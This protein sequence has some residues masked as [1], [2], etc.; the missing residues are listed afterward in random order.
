MTVLGIAL[1]AFLIA[2]FVPAL[3]WAFALAVVSEPL[4]SWIRAR[5]AS[6]TLSAGIAVFLV[7]VVLLVPTF[8]IVWQVGQ[9]AGQ[10][11]R[12]IVEFIDSGAL[13]KQ[14]DRLPGGGR[15]YD[16]V[17]YGG[18]PPSK[19]G[20]GQL[21][22]AVPEQAG[23]WLQAAAW[24]LTQSVVAL[25]VL[26]FLFR[27]RDAVLK[28]FRG[29]MPMSDAE[30]DYFF[31]RIRGMTHATIYGNV[32]TSIIQGALGGAMFTLLGIPS[33]LLWAVAMAFLS[34]IPFAGAFIIWLP[35]AVALAAH[36]EWGKAILLAAWGA[37]VVGTIDNIL[38]P[39]LV[40]KQAKL[41]T[42]A[43]FL[44][45]IGG[46]VAFGAPGLVLGPVVVAG[47]IAILDILRRRTTR[48]RSALQPT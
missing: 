45:I 18:R 15:I 11:Y 36:G 43:V 34:L 2:P 9:Q 42:L 31:E 37:L 21:A 13:R 30:V 32:V 5:L 35:A 33:A 23:V 44:A 14:A 10:R 19:A 39:F 25:F 47:T 12:Q 3:T 28:T 6:P 29:Y 27:D 41:H 38:Y 1:S 22:S 16:T 24:A 20:E 8:V 48:S 46:L 7:T 26:F 4:H 17:V 40:G